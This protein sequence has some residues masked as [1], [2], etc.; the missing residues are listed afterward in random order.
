[1][2]DQFLSKKITPSPQSQQEEDPES[3]DELEESNPT[4]S[5][6]EWQTV[7]MV[8]ML[9]VLSVTGAAVCCETV[10]HESSISNA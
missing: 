3:Q 4:A 2:N 8:V 7:S 1:M 10:L 9:G 5:H 6:P